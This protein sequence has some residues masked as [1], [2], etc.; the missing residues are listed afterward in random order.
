MKIIIRFLKPAKKAK[1]GKRKEMVVKISHDLDRQKGVFN[2][3]L[4]EGNNF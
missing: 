2:Y 3:P 1:A 4:E